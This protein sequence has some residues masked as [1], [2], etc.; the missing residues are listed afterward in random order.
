MSFPLSTKNLARASALHPWRTVIIWLI[1]LV[2][3]VVITG[4]Y[5]ADGLTTE[6]SVTNNPESQRGDDLL[7]AR[8]TGPRQLNE[9]VIVRSTTLTVDDAA[10]RQKVEAVNAVATASVNEEG[11]KVVDSGITYYGVQ[12]ETLVSKDRRATILP[13]VLTGDLDAANENVVF[14][15]DAVR[16]L[17]GVD[18]FEVLQ[19]G[20]A[21]I[22][23]D[24]KEIS[25]K[26][27]Q[28]GEMFGAPLAI[29][30]LILVLGAIVAALL[31]LLI[32]IVSIA[33]ALG[34]ASIVGQIFPLSFFVQNMIFMI[35]LA[36]G[37]DYALF[38]IHRFR[39]ERAN[40]MEKIAAIEKA[41]A[42]ASR[43]VFFSGVTVFLALFGML[44]IPSNV[45]RGVGTGSILVV[46]VAVAA[47]LTLLPAIL[48]ILGDRINK[49]TIP[50]IGK[51]QNR[52]DEERAG[53]FWDK[54]SRAVMRAPLV[55]LILASSVLLALAYPL[56]SLHTGAASINS[57]PDSLESKQAYVVLASDFSAGQASPAEIVIDGDINNPA[58]RDAMDRLKITLA[59]DTAAF[60]PVSERVNDAR[61]LAVISAPING[62]DVTSDAAVA[63]VRKL[64]KETIPPI[65]NGVPA[66]A[67]VT[68]ET[69]LN[70]DFFDV[71]RNATLPVFIFVLSMSFILLTLVFRSIVVAIKSII[72]NLLSVGAAYGLVVL[73]FQKGFL[74]STLGFGQVEAIEAWIP[75]F[76]FS[77]LFGLS[78]DY[79]VFLLSRIRERYDLTG[80]NTGA[81]AYGIRSTGRLITGAA[82]IMVAIF[83]GFASGDLVPLQQ[84]GFGLGI[85][86]LIDAS[87]VR[88]IL[89]P[90]AMALLGKANWYLPSWLNWLPDLRVEAEAP[91]AK[92]PAIAAE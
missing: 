44:L 66:Q 1:V 3:A 89:V 53:G 11:E 20:Q 26:D 34:L 46:I 18:G 79:H 43:T 19:V 84:M 33:I 25:E 16:A 2:A 40:G 91:I 23:A 78:M 76:L 48:S 9:V 87:I 15:R 75:L 41:G 21:T 14:M 27:L 45:F 64:R 8:L 30:I 81:V 50:V 37:I 10:F 80:D 65:F 24:F 69:A 29:L 52:F 67:L 35:G 32:A 82:L 4:Q 61:D 63:I 74:A 58:V 70:A 68:G 47:S 22:N 71:A 57:F 7:E 72:L 77:V 92:K 51:M 6:F 60:G 31:P 56:L 83:M 42:T 28:T 85:A 59:A 39:E 73:V 49:L 12:D 54:M 38:I 62:G 13:Y 88:M 17:N 55:W 90:A 5:L 36:V 86:V